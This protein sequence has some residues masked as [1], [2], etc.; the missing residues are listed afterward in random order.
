MRSTSLDS[1]LSYPRRPSHRSPRAIASSV[2][3]QRSSRCVS[4]ASTTGVLPFLRF[5]ESKP[6]RRNPPPIPPALLRLFPSSAEKAVND[7][8]ARTPELYL[9]ALAQFAISA[10]TEVVRPLSSPSRTLRY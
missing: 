6:H 10:D 9:L 5:D 8:L 3:S 1:T 7:R 4:A 2:Y